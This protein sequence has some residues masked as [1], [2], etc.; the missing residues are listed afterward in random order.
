MLG[1]PGDAQSGWFIDVK[2]LPEDG[3]GLFQ[4]ITLACIYGLGL[5]YA[6]NLISD[7]SELLLLVPELAGIVGTS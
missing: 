2:A 3:H 4:V 5:T 7:G 6:A 1:G